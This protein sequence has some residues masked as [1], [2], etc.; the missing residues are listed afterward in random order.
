[1][2]K[3]KN[4]L[5]GALVVMLIAMVGLIAAFWASTVWVNVDA[6]DTVTINIADAP[7]IFTELS[8]TD[9]M[10]QLP[11]NSG[12]VPIGSTPDEHNGIA[13]VNYILVEIDIVWTFD[14]AF[15]TTQYTNIDGL[16][17][18]FDLVIEPVL[19]GVDTTAISADTLAGYVH[20]LFFENITAD[21]VDDAL[22]SDW[23]D[24]AAFIEELPDAY[25]PGD[26]IELFFG[27]AN[28]STFFMLVFIEPVPSMAYANALEKGTIT[29]TISLSLSDDQRDNQ[30]H[31]KDFSEYVPE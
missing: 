14:G 22:A 1:M 4:V 8:L 26:E 29:I 10:A 20:V 3:S 24:V 13:E 28:K 9:L 12:L 6:D 7:E 25:E 30:G 16:P 21:E 18:Y 17:G 19:S 15:T 31:I 2:K 5:I 11:A 23:A 27:V